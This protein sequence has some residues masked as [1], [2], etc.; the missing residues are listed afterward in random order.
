MGATIWIFALI[1]GLAALH[2]RHAA[3]LE[4]AEAE[5]NA[6]RDEMMKANRP[7]TLAREG[8]R[9]AFSCEQ[10]TIELLVTANEVRLTEV[11]KH[12]RTVACAH[13]CT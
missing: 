8:V 6:E 7:P 3:A 2:K 9:I 11:L 5:W 10:P 13:R 12:A 4:A 1:R